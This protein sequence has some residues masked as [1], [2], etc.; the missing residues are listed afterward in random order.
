MPLFHFAAYYSLDCRFWLALFDSRGSQK[1]KGCL[2]AAGCCTATF[3]CLPC[4]DLRFASNS[5]LCALS[6]LGYRFRMLIDLELGNHLRSLEPAD[7]GFDS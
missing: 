7:F 3:R 4:V 1:G 2:V 5:P 6:T